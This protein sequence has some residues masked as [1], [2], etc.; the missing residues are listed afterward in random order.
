VVGDSLVGASLEDL[1]RLN[2]IDP[3]Q[4]LTSGAIVKLVT[5]GR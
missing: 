1:V 5:P 4:K 2:R 3:D